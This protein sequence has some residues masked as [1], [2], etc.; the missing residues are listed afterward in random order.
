MKGVLARMKILASQI[1]EALREEGVNLNSRD[2][3]IIFNVLRKF[4]KV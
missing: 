3:D 1:H 4:F 2:E